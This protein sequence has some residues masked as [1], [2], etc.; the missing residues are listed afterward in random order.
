MALLYSVSIDFLL[1]A[2]ILTIISSCCL[3]VLPYAV[4]LP[5]ILFM[6]LSNFSLTSFYFLASPALATLAYNA[7]IL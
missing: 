2:C 7:L 4:S 3:F 6:P 5:N 1:F